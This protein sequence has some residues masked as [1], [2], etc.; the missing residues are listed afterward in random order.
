[1]NLKTKI[2]LDIPHDALAH[3]RGL[4]V[5]AGIWLRATKTEISAVHCAYVAW[6][7]SAKKQ[8]LTLFCSVTEDFSKGKKL[9]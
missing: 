8:P 6:E 7:G 1:M 5:E 9:F 2:R 3:V 4:A